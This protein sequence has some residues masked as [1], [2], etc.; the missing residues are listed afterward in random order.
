MED[1]NKT[2]KITCPEC[3]N[4]VELEAGRDYE[5]GDV[6][7]CPYCGSEMEVVAVNDEGVVEVELIE[8]EK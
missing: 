4:E 3:G 5:V 8:E 6:I 1:K 7:E 2:Q